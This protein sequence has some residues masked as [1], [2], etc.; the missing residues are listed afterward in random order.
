MFFFFLLRL[1]FT[2]TYRCTKVYIHVHVAPNQTQGM[3][4]NK[5]G[6]PAFL[7]H[8]STLQFPWGGGG[9]W[10]ITEVRRLVRKGWVICLGSNS[11]VK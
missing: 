6:N 8:T 7:L 1:I 11:K 10:F 4:Q 3:L 2:W 5:I 9:L